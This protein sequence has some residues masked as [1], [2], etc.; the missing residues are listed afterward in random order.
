MKSIVGNTATVL[1]R[2]VIQFERNMPYRLLLS[3]GGLFFPSRDQVR[4][5]ALSVCITFLATTLVRK[6]RYS[7]EKPRRI[8]H[9]DVGE[10]KRAQSSE[11]DRSVLAKYVQPSQNRAALR[12]DLTE[13]VFE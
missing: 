3:C 6:S 8:V 7:D 10:V 4:N 12:D 5:E 1:S 13:R 2:D 11:C 9:M